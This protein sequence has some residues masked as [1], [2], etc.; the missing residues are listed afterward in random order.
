MVAADGTAVNIGPSLIGKR[1]TITITVLTDGGHPTLTCQ[2]PLIDVQVRQRPDETPL[3]G[4]L[5]AVALTAVALT[6][7][8]TEA[9]G[10]AGI[11]DAARTVSVVAL[12]A[13]LGTTLTVLLLIVLAD[14]LS[15]RKRRR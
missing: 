6:V 9:A 1:H 12:L 13:L 2:S 11:G 4:R 3:A 15:G 14:L 10:A 5:L 7:A 8:G